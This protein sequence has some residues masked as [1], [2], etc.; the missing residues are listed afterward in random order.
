[1][2]K[3]IANHPYSDRAAFD[4]LLLL[5]ATL[6]QQPGVGCPSDERDQS[7]QHN[8]IA[9]LQQALATTA[10]AQGVDLPAYATATLRKDLD[11]LRQY[12][13]LGPQMYRWGYYLGD[14]ALR[15]QELKLALDAIAT[16]ADNLSDPTFQQLQIT[17]RQRFK[18]LDQHHQEHLFSPTRYLLN[19]AIHDTDPTTLV[20][21]GGN[22]N[23]IFQRLPQV[24]TAIVNRQAIEL[25]RREDVYGTGRVGPE[26]LWPLQ[27]VYHDIAWYLLYEAYPSGHFVVGRLNR[28]A[29]YCRDLPGVQRSPAQHQAQLTAALSLLDNGWG[30]YL[31]KPA[32]Q[33]AER[34]GTLLLERV[35]VRFFPP[36]VGFILEGRLRHCRQKI[37]KGPKDSQGNY[38]HVDYVVRLPPR[39]LDEFSRWVNRHM[40]HAQVLSP[41]SLVE[42]H[43][44]AAMALA[45]RYR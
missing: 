35:K 12:G 42:C 33:Q 7:Q 43:R 45:D 34:Q 38:R 21:E 5:I 17:L 3:P 13:I 14:G 9:L 2:V 6:A 22:P 26:Q 25:S 1:M 40:Q 4:R 28:F 16:L 32:E 41:P 29:D 27:L 20:A 31:G 8:A 39:S 11:T 37:V 36:V 30:L 19:R 15:L 23:S 24:E 18:S 10:A 44:S